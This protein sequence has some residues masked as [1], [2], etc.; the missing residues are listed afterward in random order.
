MLEPFPVSG[1]VMEGFESVRA[2]FEKNFAPHPIFRLALETYR[3]KKVMILNY[4]TLSI[5][6]KEIEK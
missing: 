6:V 3:Q 5:Q 4:R 1:W 2:A